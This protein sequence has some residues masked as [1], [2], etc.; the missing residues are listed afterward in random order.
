MS[1]TG[2]RV[3]AGCADPGGPLPVAS[4]PVMRRLGLATLLVAVLWLVVEVAV[5]PLVEG[6]IERRVGSGP[7]GPADVQAD[8]GSFP[9]V[10]RALIAQRV[11]ALD[12][13]LRGIELGSVP[14]ALL[15]LRLRDVAVARGPL[16]RGGAGIRGVDEVAVRAEVTA[17]G[18]GEALDP[19][20]GGLPD[21]P[22]LVEALPCMPDVGLSGLRMVLTCTA[23]TLP[24]RMAGTLR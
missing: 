2:A 4:S 20:G 16:L 19:D 5:P 24:E 21:V 10:S 11:P 6:R 3:R 8:L 9:V 17:G 22:G 12:L 14:V 13:T 15:R 23:G 7:G 1:G 18:V